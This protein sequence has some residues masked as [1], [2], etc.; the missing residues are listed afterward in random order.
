MAD[1]VSDFANETFYM[2]YTME[3]KFTRRQTQ[4]VAHFPRDTDPPF[5]H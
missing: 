4:I 1:K 5:M 3:I 2:I